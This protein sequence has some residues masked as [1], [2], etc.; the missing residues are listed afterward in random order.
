MFGKPSSEKG[1]AAFPQL[2]I[3]ALLS[4]QLRSILDVAYGP[5]LGK[6]TFDKL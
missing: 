3:V 5:Y 6:G 1:S 2:R 4:L